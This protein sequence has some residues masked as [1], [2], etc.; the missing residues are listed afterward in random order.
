MD[1]SKEH[2]RSFTKSRVLSNPF[3]IFGDESDT[4]DENE[5]VVFV[6]I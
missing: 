4:K 6:G 5:G 1:I 3:D 2:G